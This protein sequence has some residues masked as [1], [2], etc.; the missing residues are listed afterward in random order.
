MKVIDKHKSSLIELIDSNIIIRD[1]HTENIMNASNILY[2]NN[3]RYN[4]MQG[5]IL[6]KHKDNSLEAYI[7]IEVYIMNKKYY[8][9]IKEEIML[10][11]IL[12]EGVH[13]KKP[14]IKYI[15]KILA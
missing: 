8:L 11:H 13:R 4:I 6:N 5:W 7:Y 3:I 14:T 15:K 9:D 12:C 1:N 2:T 10:T